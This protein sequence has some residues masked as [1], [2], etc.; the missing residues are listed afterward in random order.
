MN[1]IHSHLDEVN[2]IAKLADLKHAHYENT[3]LVN[4]LIELLVEKEIITAR[5]ITTMSAQLDLALTPH[6]IDPT[7]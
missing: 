1:R 7:L 3:L 6:P 4:A 5:D 2:W